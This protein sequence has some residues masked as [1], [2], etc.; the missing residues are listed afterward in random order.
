M[1]SIELAAPSA[2]QYRLLV[3]AITDY[4]IY[5]L[6]PEGLV[7]SWNAGAKRFKGYEEHEVL[8]KHFSMFYT[9][10]DLASGLP[11][12]AL[13]V[14]AS[15]GRFETQGWRLRKDGTRFWAH[16]VI[17]PIMGQDGAL[18]G[19][20]KITRDITDR[21]RAE[22]EL[23]RS[24]DM[25]RRLVLGVTDYALY[26]I[27][28]DGI[29]T[30]WNAGAERIKGYTPE[31]IV[32]QHFERF[33]TQEDRASGAPA[34]ALEVAR[35]TGKFEKE[36]W[37]VR[38]DGTRF[39]AHV[40]IDAIR[41]P[42]G[43]LIGFAKITRDITE[44]MRVQQELET[45]REQL[46]QSQK[47][48]AIGQLTGGVAH[49][50]NNLLMAVLSSLELLRKRL[51]DDPQALRLLDNARQGAERGAALTR[52]MLAFARR[53][54]MAIQPVDVADLVR[55]MQEMLSSSLGAMIAVD[56]AF[57]T[58]LPPA[59][60]DPNH[61]A[62]AIL[63]LTVNARDAMPGGGTIRI[64]ATQDGEFVRLSIADSGEGMD[65]AVLARAR[66]PFFTTKGV[67]KGTGLGLSMVHGIAE[68]SG[69]RLELR[70]K[71]GEGTVAELWLPVAQA[72]PGVQTPAPV[73][74]VAAEPEQRRLR[75]LAVDDDYLVL[76]NT[77]TMLEDLGHEVVEATSAAEALSR[78]E[79]AEFDLVISDHA[80]PK[81][82][83]AQLA[84]V[85]AGKW[86]GMPVLIA[87]G[88]AELP[89][90]AGRRLPKLSK[91]FSQNQLH[92][93]IWEIVR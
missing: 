86:P 73:A 60:S 70:S 66:E 89:E 36:G 39:M 26:M 29:V 16:A 11:D 58:N 77:A 87:T 9:P 6:T 82:T 21:R 1:T 53:Q 5:M 40:V 56:I 44:R 57:P 74:V 81:M 78:L 49:D 80:M 45:A 52:S 71:P 61:L 62:T 30:N 51:P 23:A 42:D 28:P 18:L 48:E 79:E 38:K 15:A 92:D 10:E 14:A 68:Q 17:D 91:P 54:D 27:S 84:E 34:R 4:G 76:M 63:N 67:G 90:G 24:Q 33:Y 2:E 59:L 47:M 19:F 88:Y 72:E 75:V 8:G 3:E 85:V 35:E 64:S 12:H 55:S 93:A 7:S 20:A 31:E 13:Q 32:G 50:F 37:R 22:I 25:F 65:E 83:G 46:L 41:D 69:G 43:S